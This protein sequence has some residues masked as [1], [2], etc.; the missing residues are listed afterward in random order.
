[1][2]SRPGHY[3][4]AASL[5]VLHPLSL[6]FRFHDYTRQYVAML[7]IHALA[8]ERL[9]SLND[10]TTSSPPAAAADCRLSAV[11]RPKVGSFLPQLIN[12]MVAFVG[13]LCIEFCKRCLI[14]IIL[15]IV[16]SACRQN[17]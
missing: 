15:F 6:L 11:Y 12:L 14:L 17:V 4:M 9:A 8:E 16:Q 2:P 13:L 10:Y 3:C 7:Q 5:H 1:M